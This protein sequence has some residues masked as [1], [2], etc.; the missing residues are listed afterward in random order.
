MRKTGKKEKKHLVWDHH[1]SRMNRR[2]N[3]RE[4]A[5]I[6]V[7]EW[8]RAANLDMFLQMVFHSKTK[9][10]R[11][12]NDVMIRKHRPFRIPRCSWENKNN[13]L[14]KYLEVF[15]EFVIH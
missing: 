1:G 6:R 14:S 10:I 2:N 5:W 12:V 4:H 15:L 9:E 8:Q 11:V 13:F 7:V 3:I